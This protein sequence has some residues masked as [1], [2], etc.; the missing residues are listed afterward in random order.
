MLASSAFSID[1]GA[2]SNVTATAGNLTLSTVTSGSLLLTSAGDS[3]FTV[4]NASA[5][6]LTLTD[7]TDVLM[8]A[9]TTAGLEQVDVQKMLQISGG[10]GVEIET[11]AALAAGE[12]VTI[13]ASGHVQLADADHATFRL[14]LVNGVSRGTFSAA[15]QAHLYTVP[16][17]VIPVLF[18]SAPAG[19]EN[20]RPVYLS[21]TAGQGTLSPPT[22]TGT[23]RF[24]VGYLIGADGADTTPDVL[25]Q[26]QYISRRP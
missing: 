9:D 5:T 8:V 13:N 1:G 12:L 3:T 17:S 22:G 24:L 6:A 4:P 15:Q 7:G 16:G 18:A 21:A 20:G 19:A 25:Y 23:T 26:P 11:D 10:A 2:A 14:S